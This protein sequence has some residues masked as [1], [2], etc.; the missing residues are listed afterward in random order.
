MRQTTFRDFE[1]DERYHKLKRSLKLAML[2]VNN[3]R[4]SEEEADAPVSLPGFSSINGDAFNSSCATVSRTSLRSEIV[5]SSNNLRNLLLKKP[6]FYNSNQKQIVTSSVKQYD[7]KHDN[8]IDR[9]IMPPPETHVF[10]ASK[11]SVVN[12]LLDCENTAPVVLNN[13]VPFSTVYSLSSKSTSTPMSPS[14]NGDKEHQPTDRVFS[15]WKVM[16]DRQLELRIK[17]TLKW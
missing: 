12:T 10:H 17:G 2:K 9:L 11:K 4:I 8:D 6:T 1:A 16:L 3:R 15:K 13:S 7:I 14:T 5:S